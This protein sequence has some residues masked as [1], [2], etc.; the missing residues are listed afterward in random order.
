MSTLALEAIGL[1]LKRFDKSRDQDRL[2]DHLRETLLRELSVNKELV[3]EANRLLENDEDRE[4]G[5]QLLRKI[6]LD[7]FNAVASVGIPLKELLPTAWHAP[8]SHKLSKRFSWHTRGITNVAA[9]V[10]RTYHRLLIQSIRSEIGQQKQ[11]ESLEYL[12]ALLIET[13]SAVDAI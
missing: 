5:E 2:Y 12:E 1:L 9:L 11:P 8:D 4:T 10:E 13:V 3:A 7:S 6:R